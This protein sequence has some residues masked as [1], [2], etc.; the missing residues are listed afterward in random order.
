MRTRAVLRL[1]TLIRYFKQEEEERGRTFRVVARQTFRRKMHW[2]TIIE[3]NL[4][5][6]IMVSIMIS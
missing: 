4:T 3:Q 6:N 1:S 2:E 5:Y